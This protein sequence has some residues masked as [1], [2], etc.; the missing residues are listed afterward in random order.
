MIS[1]GG[2]SQVR[3]CGG[4]GRGAWVGMICGGDGFRKRKKARLYVRK[5]EEGQ[6][7]TDFP[8]GMCILIFHFH[9][10]CHNFA[11]FHLEPQYFDF[12]Y[13]DLADFPSGRE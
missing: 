12:P 13:V 1:T 5:I 8:E 9:S 2:F 10:G 7:K 3:G 11:Y 4:E 6:E